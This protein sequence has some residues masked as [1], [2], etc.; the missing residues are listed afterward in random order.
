MLR[1]CVRSFR[2]VSG[3]LF[4][5][6]CP[7]PATSV[8]KPMVRAAVSLLASSRSVPEI[9]TSRHGFVRNGTI[10]RIPGPL[11]TLSLGPMD[12]RLPMQCSATES[13]SVRARVR[14]QARQGRKNSS[15]RTYSAMPPSRCKPCTRRRVDSLDPFGSRGRFHRDGSAGRSSARSFSLISYG[16]TGF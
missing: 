2:K 3:N 5:R 15:S 12:V 16:R 1:Q 8:S 14:D 7:G 13:G 9:M 10:G 4:V 11:V 6:G